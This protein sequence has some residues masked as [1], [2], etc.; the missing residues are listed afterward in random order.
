MTNNKNIILKN[1]ITQFLTT[2]PNSY[3]TISNQI[4]YIMQ[5]KLGIDKNIASSIHYHKVYTWAKGAI[6]KAL[7]MK[8]L[9][10]LKYSDENRWLDLYIPSTEIGI[11]ILKDSV[12]QLLKTAYKNPQK[13]KKEVLSLNEEKASMLINNPKSSLIY[14]TYVLI[15]KAWKYYI[16]KQTITTT[17]LPQFSE[18][19]ITPVENT[20]MLFINRIQFQ[21]LFANTIMEDIRKNINLHNFE[22][23]TVKINIKSIML[24]RILMLIL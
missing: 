23:G 11:N 3:H 14:K 2:N 16:L 7:E 17:S 22:D 6:P 20:I 4:E 10:Y 8:A 21:S 15:Y 12:H 13:L 24:N 19:T 5:E 1:G 9:A 18:N